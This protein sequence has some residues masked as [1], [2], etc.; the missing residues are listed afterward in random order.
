MNRNVQYEYFQMIDSHWQSIAT[1]DRGPMIKPRDEIQGS[2]NTLGRLG[3]RGIKAIPL[4]NSDCWEATY[5]ER[6]GIKN[7]HDFPIL[8]VVTK[9]VPSC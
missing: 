6:H 8:V 7:G 2:S 4:E 9:D 1:T 3:F 5:K